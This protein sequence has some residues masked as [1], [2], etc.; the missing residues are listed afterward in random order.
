MTTRIQAPPRAVRIASALTFVQAL[1]GIALAVA[2]VIRV[3]G[4][5]TPAGPILGAAG[6]LV[7]WFGGALLAT[8]MLFRGHHGARTPVIVTQLLLIGCAWYA[9]G[10]SEQ[11]LLGSL[12]GIYCVVVLV[13]L[14]TR[15]GRKWALGLDDVSEGDKAD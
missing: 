1:G 12:G 5:S 11:P 14:F 4:G 9:Y 15:D 10:P 3:I 7:I 8:V 2:L 13:F 6:V